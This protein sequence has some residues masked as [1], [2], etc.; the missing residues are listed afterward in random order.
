[1]ASQEWFW[2]E[3]RVNLFG[4]TFLVLIALLEQIWH[5]DIQQVFY[6]F[7]YCVHVFM[8]VYAK[9]SARRYVSEGCI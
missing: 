6:A 9:K 5:F 7:L 4:A 1:M 3:N 8:T 2:L